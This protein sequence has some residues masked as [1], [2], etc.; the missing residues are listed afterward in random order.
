MLI[1]LG[2]LIVNSK[3]LKDKAM[4]KKNNFIGFVVL[5]VLTLAPSL[6]LSGQ[7]NENGGPPPWAPA[8]GYRA[9]TRH[10]YFP[11]YNFYFDV[12]R[13]VY[14]YLEGSNWQV[15]ANIPI[16]YA[17]LNLKVAAKVELDLNTDTPQKYNVDH[18]ARYKVKV[19]S[20]QELTKSKNTAK[21]KMK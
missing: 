11:D 12:Q 6:V 16:M 3:T 8:H 9:K 10:I 20:R 5:I 17:G 15:N 18:I 19:P 1:S 7:R 4:K 14:I 2:F 21:G 13:N